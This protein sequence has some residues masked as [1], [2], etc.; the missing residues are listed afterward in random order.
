[1]Q[2]QRHRVFSLALVVTYVSWGYNF[3]ALKLM[4]SYISAPALALTRWGAMIAGLYAFCLISRVPRGIPRSDLLLVLFQGFLSLG[5]YMVL[6]LE[7]TTRTGPGEASIVLATAPLFTALFSAL[8]KQE[9]LKRETVFWS[10][11]AFA[12]VSMVVA[13]H[14][15]QGGL[16]GDLLI[17]GSAVVWAVATVISKPLVGKYPPATVLTVSMWGALPIILPYGYSQVL[18][19]NWAALPPVAI[20]HWVF[21][22]LVAGVF[23]F[24]CFYVGVKQVGASGTMIYQYAVPPLANLFAW[25][26]LGQSLTGVQWLGFVIAFA[27]VFL[28]QRSRLR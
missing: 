8:A 21:V 28:A 12:G 19:T 20:W 6:F 25:I 17:L 10:L 9:V 13:G 7:G 27:G 24:V 1:M 14:G 22:A 2:D 3:V 4:W 23:G 5:I 26:V 15:V 18:A 16:V 11:F